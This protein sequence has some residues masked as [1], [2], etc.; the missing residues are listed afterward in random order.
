[1]RKAFTLIELLVV[2]AI[3][4]ILAAILFPV[5]AQAKVA[6]KKA[7]SLA[8]IKQM[9]TAAIIYQAD[10]DD[11][12]PGAFGYYPGVGH[13]VN[14]G[15]DVPADWYP[16][17][18]P[19]YLSFANGNPINS[20][21]PYRKN[22][23]LVKIDGS[24]ELNIFNDD[25]SIAVKTPANVSYTYNGLLH[26]YNG[27]AVNRV[28]DTPLFTSFYGNVNFKGYSI[29][30]PSLW[31]LNQPNA[32]CRYVPKSPSCSSANGQWTVVI[33]GQDIIGSQHVFGRG[34]N[35]V[36]VDSSA[37][38]RKMGMN[39][40]GASDFRKDP[41]TRYNAQGV[42]NGAWYDE[43]YCH[44]YHFTPDWDGTVP[45]APFEETWF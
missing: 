4:A 18:G 44:M 33:V 1:M 40:N 24:R 7:K 27:T 5:F 3:I 12:L 15:H 31:C 37:K 8:E 23:S 6:A 14:Y 35:W 2:I 16:G 22:Y 17:V 26:H 11:T 36:Y 25:F 32:T 21:E 43:F 42:K 9:G 19:T 10:F 20:T 13:M 34:E 29:S 28:S 38:F 39:F 41:Y 45:T 30:S